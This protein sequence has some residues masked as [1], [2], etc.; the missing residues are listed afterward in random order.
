MP[1]KSSLLVL[2]ML[3]VLSM[4]NLLAQKATYVGSKKC[5]MCHTK[6]GVY[7]VWEQTKHASAFKSLATEKG[8]GDVKCLVCHVISVDKKDLYDEGVGCEKCHGPG[9]AYM[10]VMKDKEKSKAAGLLLQKDDAKVCTQCHKKEGNTHYKDFKYSTFWPKIA[11]I[12]K[13]G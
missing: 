10:K 9:S 4:S 1:K 8:Q 2:A 11:H 13:K 12:M 7:K 6:D 3:V 5:K